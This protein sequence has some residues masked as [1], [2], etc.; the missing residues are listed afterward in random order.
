MTT[1]YIRPQTLTEIDSAIASLEAQIA[2]LTA[3]GLERGSVQKVSG[4]SRHR[5]VW[6]DADRQ[7]VVASPVLDPAVVPQMRAAHQRWRDCQNLRA[8]V[9]D[10][11]SRRDRMAG[12]RTA[13]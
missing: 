4:S 8:A 13:A 1:L 9:A 11:Q 7:K 10:L 3:Q 12:V 6:W 2:A 5:L